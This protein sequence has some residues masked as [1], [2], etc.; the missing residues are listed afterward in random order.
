MLIEEAP[1][2][3]VDTETTGVRAETDRL[4]EIA[5][6]KLVG[7]EVVD[8]FSS[9]I[10]PERSIPQRITRLTGISTGMVF[11]QPP[12]AEVMPR[13]LAFLGEGIFVAHNRTFDERFVNAELARLERQVELGQQAYDQL[14]VQYFNGTGTYLEV[15]TALDDLQQLRRD[16][17]STRLALVESRIALY[18]AL[19]GPVE[20][21]AERDA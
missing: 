1:F 17:L 10:N 12:A 2:V 19:A 20:T 16:L 3:V 8:R 6:V 14:R 13:F 7:G 21:P 5:A 18:R 15:L 4:I 11:D 9:L